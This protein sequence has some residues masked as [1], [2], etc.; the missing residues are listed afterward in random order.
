MQP[1]IETYMPINAEDYN[2]PN[3]ME[4]VFDLR[5]YLENIVLFVQ[6]VPSQW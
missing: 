6:I 2:H 3:N 5:L 1:F 4:D